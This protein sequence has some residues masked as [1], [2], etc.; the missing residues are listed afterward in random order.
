MIR[1]I[2]FFPILSPIEIIV[3]A[4]SLDYSKVFINAPVPVF[5]SKTKPSVPLANF[6]LIIELEIK[7]IDSTVPVTSYFL[8]KIKFILVF[9][10]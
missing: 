1:A 5:T 4:N 9:C 6:L 10:F 7:G 8:F 2:I 3:S